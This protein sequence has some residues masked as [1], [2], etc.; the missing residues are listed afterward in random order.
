MMMALAANENRLDVAAKLSLD[1]EKGS[2]L[3]FIEKTSVSKFTTN[4][5]TQ[6]HNHTLRS[7]F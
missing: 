1:P 2:A 3:K 6:N 7:F 4:V 5:N